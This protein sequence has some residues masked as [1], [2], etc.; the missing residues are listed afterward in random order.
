MSPPHDSLARRVALITGASRKLGAAIATAFSYRGARVVVN[1]NTSA[2]EAE[3]LVRSLKAEGGEAVAIQGDV[4]DPQAIAGLVEGALGAFGAL[5]ILVNNAGPY[6][7]TSLASLPPEDWD[8]IIDT[9]LK[10]AYYASQLA[11]RSME[12][13]GWGRIVS[14]SAGSAF[15]RNHSVYGLAK[16]ALLALTE[17]LALDFAPQVT[18]NAVAPGLID[19]PSVPEPLKKAVRQDTPLKRIVTYQQVADMVCLICSP[20]FDTVTGQVIVMDGGQTIPRGM[21]FEDLE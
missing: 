9:N 6:T 3:A 8:W 14:I 5:D 12:A 18:V 20:S 19:D 17:S 10:A 16:S 11:F 15:V 7:D 2:S 4:S 1:Y 13:R 21:T